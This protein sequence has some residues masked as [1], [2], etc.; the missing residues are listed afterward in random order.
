VRTKSTE[1]VWQE[2]VRIEIIKKIDEEESFE[3][4]NKQIVR[5]SSIGS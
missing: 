3:E 1:S 5:L 2:M 4:M